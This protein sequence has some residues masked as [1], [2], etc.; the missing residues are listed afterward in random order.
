MRPTG[1]RSS[2]RSIAAATCSAWSK[3]SVGPMH[4]LFWRIFALFWIASVILIVAMTWITSNK[5]EN[6]KIPG[7]GITRMDSMLNDQLRSA[8][9]ALNKGGIDGLRH[10]LET[11]HGFA[12]LSLYVLD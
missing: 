5:F 1:N 6:E 12:S 3:V 10:H 4:R 9:H 2:T 8:A 7:L 11:A